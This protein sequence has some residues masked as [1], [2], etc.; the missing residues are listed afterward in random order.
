MTLRL[1]GPPMED[2]I[3]QQKFDAISLAWPVTPL[4]A[5][6]VVG[7]AGQPAF[8]NGWANTGAGYAGAQ[9]YKD[10]AGIVHVEGFVTG[11]TLNTGVFTLP[12]GYR[13]AA[14]LV[15]AS[16]QNGVYCGLQ[17]LST[18]VVQQIS[19]AAV[20]NFTITC[21]FRQEA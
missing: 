14:N 15:F 8:A 20:V 17:V 2:P 5:W 4:E 13:P 18:G 1:P 11:G 10:P 6:H 9:F 7:A 21:S 16:W 3:L 19:A 12:V